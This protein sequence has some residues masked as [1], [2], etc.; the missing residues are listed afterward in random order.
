VSSAIDDL[1]NLGS[2]EEFF[3]TLDVPFDPRVLRVARLHIL[4]RMGQIIGALADDAPEADV[5]AACR[6][7]LAAAYEEFTT[8]AP[9][10]TRLFKVLRDRDPARPA[11]HGGFVPLS[12]LTG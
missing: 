2:A 10:E 4:K 12:D 7:A 1:K 9:I 5:H 3:R 6:E 11:P 8:K